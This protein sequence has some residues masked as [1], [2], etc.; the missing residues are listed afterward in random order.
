MQ[1]AVQ[2]L[3]VKHILVV[4]HYGCGGVRAALN[5]LRVGLVDNWLRHIHDVK[6]KHQ[7]IID[8]APAEERLDRLCELNVI[9]QVLNLAQSTVIY[10]AWARGQELSVHGLIYGLRDGIVRNLNISIHSINS[11]CPAYNHAL[12]SFKS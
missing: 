8:A 7:A 2:V 6:Q 3:R 5:D 4:G 11:I 1:F 9:E 10:D 12:S